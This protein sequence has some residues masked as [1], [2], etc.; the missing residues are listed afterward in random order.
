MQNR[1]K[2][3]FLSKNTRKELERFMIVPLQNFIPQSLNFYVRGELCGK[4]SHFQTVTCEKKI[5]N[6][7]KHKYFNMQ[8]M[9]SEWS[10]SSLF[11]WT[12]QQVCC[13]VLIQRTTR[14]Y[15]TF[16]LK[17]WWLFLSAPAH[18]Q[19]T[20]QTFCLSQNA[21]AFYGIIMYIQSL[22]IYL[23]LSPNS[24]VCRV[25]N[26]FLTALLSDMTTPPPT[27]FTLL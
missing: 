22:N 16:C 12:L 11:F 21:S 27:T 5:V 26:F 15:K 3:E 2:Y 7:D 14:S 6:V 19:F 1:E 13:F 23:R 4:V 25:S 24:R 20:I 8:L 10:C 9:Q 17:S 18:V